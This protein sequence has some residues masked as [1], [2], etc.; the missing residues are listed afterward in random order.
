[1]KMNNYNLNIEDLLSF[2][3][4][5][6]SSNNFR[7][8]DSERIEVLSDNLSSLFIDIY[9]DGFMIEADNGDFTESYE[10][11]SLE[12]LPNKLREAAFEFNIELE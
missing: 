8:E 9:Q 3:E 11:F 12:E 1:M 6:F 5:Y 2:L 7:I 10:V 4:E